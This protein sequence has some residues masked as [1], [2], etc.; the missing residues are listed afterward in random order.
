MCSLKLHMKA[1]KFFFINSCLSILLFYAWIECEQTKSMC[2]FFIED[3]RQNVVIIKFSRE[4]LAIKFFPSLLPPYSD[5]PG[6]KFI[7]ITGM[8]LATYKKG[9]GVL[10]IKTGLEQ[11]THENINRSVM[12]L[13]F[14]LEGCCLYLQIASPKWIYLF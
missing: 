14:L 5:L 12:T 7:Y 10:D 3:L 1:N 6:L 2:Y 9:I 11:C 13:I 8:T 4:S